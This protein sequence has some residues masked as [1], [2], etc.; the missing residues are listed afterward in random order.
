[1]LR[2][3]VLLIPLLLAACG[4][5]T[6][7]GPPP[8]APQTIRLTSP[9]FR[10]GGT[11]PKRFTCDG[12]GD[13]P[14]LDWTG[15]PSRARELALLVEDP[16]APNGTFVHWT[17]YGIP[18]DLGNLAAGP[19][20]APTGS[21]EGQNSSQENGYRAP[22]PPEDDPPH[23]YVFTLYALDRTL[24]LKEGASGEEV[25]S[26]IEGGAIARGRLVGRY[27]R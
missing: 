8:K 23:R 16:D 7:E 21:R 2:R 5:D 26:A 1:M 6:V 25:R 12:T 19:G 20:A 3:L 22:C 9:F 4:S 10:D 15:V 13:S 14:T 11:I 18:A 17:V 27:G 24:P